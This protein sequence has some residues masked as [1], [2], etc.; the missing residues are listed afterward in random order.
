MRRSRRLSKRD[1]QPEGRAG[2][3]DRQRQS[4]QDHERLEQVVAGGNQYDQRRGE[5]QS[6]DR[7]PQH[8]GHPCAE[9]SVPG[10]GQGDRHP[11]EHDQALGK[12]LQHD[13]DRQDEHQERQREGGDGGYPLLHGILSPGQSSAANSGYTVRAGLR[14][15]Q[16]MLAQWLTPLILGALR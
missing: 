13:L 16:R 5:R 10:G 9:Q 15:K 12:L 8:P 7:D 3:G 2:R 14:G 6:P 11:R 1:V 4:G